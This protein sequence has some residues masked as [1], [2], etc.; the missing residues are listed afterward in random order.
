MNGF[1]Y[2]T[3]LCEKIIS[4]HRDI[5]GESVN[6]DNFDQNRFN[7]LFIREYLKICK[8]GMSE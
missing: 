7:K 3:A 1:S 4:A 8:I 2:N 5:L 6:L